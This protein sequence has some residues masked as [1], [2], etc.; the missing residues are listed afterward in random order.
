[1]IISQEKA[2]EHLHSVYDHIDTLSE[3][4]VLLYDSIEDYIFE[5]IDFKKVA[6]FLPIWISDCGKSP[7]CGMSKEFFEELRQIYDDGIT[8]KIIYWYDI[9][10]LLVGVQ[11]RITCVISYFDALYKIV[12]FYAIHETNEY[13]SCTR[14]LNPQSDLAH[15]YINNVF[16][17]LST[18]FDL[19]SKLVYEMSHLDKYDFEQYKKLK[20]R[21][22]NILFSKSIDTFD[23]LKVPGMLYSEPPC[24]RKVI[25]FRDEFIHNGTWDYRCA[26]Y[27]PWLMNDEPAEAFILAP[28]TTEIGT[29]VSSGSRNKFYVQEDKINVSLP[30]IIEDV[31]EVLDKTIIEFDRVLK[32]NTVV[33]ENREKQTKRYIKKL[34]KYQIKYMLQ[35]MTCEEVKSIFREER[36]KS[37]KK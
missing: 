28:D 30:F 4:I 11:D 15:A 29:L 37:E 22:K 8:N 33:E 6:S 32:E 34:F 1:M 21:Q 26:I 24:I 27:E 16:I 12:P 31:L 14:A 9:Q 19:F 5:D 36:L 17:S 13:K 25:S 18:S 2:A 20:S 3:R 10:N 35:H 23:E 7:E